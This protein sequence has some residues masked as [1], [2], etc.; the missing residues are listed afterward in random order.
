M[1]LGF[2]IIIYRFLGVID[3]ILLMYSFFLLEVTLVNSDLVFFIVKI[4]HNKSPINEVRIGSIVQNVDRLG[5]VD[6]ELDVAG[7]DSV[8]SQV[9][10]LLICGDS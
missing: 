6:T 5:H 8:L 9:Y 7:Q 3:K 1:Q 2:I 10:E 4:V